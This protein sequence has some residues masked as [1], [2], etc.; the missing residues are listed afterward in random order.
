MAWSLIPLIYMLLPSTVDDL[1]LDD[2][3]NRNLTMASE[4]K[5]SKG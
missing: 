5:I 3:Q 2:F 4:K 1:S